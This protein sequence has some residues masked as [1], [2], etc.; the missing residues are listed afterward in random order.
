MFPPPG[1]DTPQGQTVAH[2]AQALAELMEGFEPDLVVSDILTLAPTLAAEVA[3][4]R[5]ATLI[6]HVYPVQAPGQPVYSLGFWPARTGFGRRAWNATMPLIDNGLRQGRDEMNV[7]QGAAGAAARGAVPRRDQRGAGAR[8]DL[9]AAGVPAR[10]AGRDA[11][12][13]AAL[14]RAA[15]RARR[16]ARGTGAAGGRRAEHRAGPGVRAGP[17]RARGT[18]RRA[19]AG[20]GD[21]QPPR[22]DRADRGAGERGADRLA[23][24]LAGDAAGRPGDLP[25]RARHGR[26]VRSTR[27]PRCSAARRAATW[28]RT[29]RGSRGPARGCRC[30]GGWC[31]RA[32]SGWRR[33]G[34]WATRA[35]GRGREEIAAWSA[36]N[37]G[38]VRASELV[39]KAAA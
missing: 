20:A 10:V 39:E 17:R 16:G 35:T 32:G 12:D 15:R 18:G 24:L 1:P 11:C 13:G 6:P 19:R 9:P 3:G 37:D 25:R 33:G 28:E 14:L 36:A 30:R 31:R 29:A 5:H 7:T 34:C 38:A 27:A 8:G 22:A 26:R 21:D 23:P 4:V 2:A